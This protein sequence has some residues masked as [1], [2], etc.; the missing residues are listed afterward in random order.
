MV[1]ANLM[2]FFIIIY[3]LFNGIPQPPD[4]MPL[5]W[6]YTI[7]YITPFT[8]WT[9]GTMAILLDRRPVVCEADELVYFELPIDNIC[10][11]F[12][13]PFLQSASGYISNANESRAGE[14]C[15]YCRYS[16]GEDVRYP[17]SLRLNITG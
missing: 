10:G 8:Y 17:M 11:T 4:Q 9:G 1:A 12:A 7:Y 13:E 16:S 14:L 6:R 2:P 5:F 3:E 15:G